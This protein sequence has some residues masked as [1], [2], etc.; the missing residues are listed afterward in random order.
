MDRHSKMKKVK[1]NTNKN[2]VKNYFEIITK[3]IIYSPVGKRSINSTCIKCNYERVT[4]KLIGKLTGNSLFSI[5]MKRITYLCIYA[6][7][8]LFDIIIYFLVYVYSEIAFLFLNIKN[9]FPPTTIFKRNL[10][11]TSF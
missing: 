8:M 3:S 5:R 1:G 10:P 2:L 4:Q 9:L 7:Y 11:T 6:L